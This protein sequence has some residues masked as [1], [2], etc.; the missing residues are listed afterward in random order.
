MFPKKKD[1]KS[2]HVI[3]DTKSHE[4]DLK[5]FSFTFLELPK[6]KKDIDELSNTTRNVDVFF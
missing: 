6:F 1:Y 3:L 4:N 5:D 2:D